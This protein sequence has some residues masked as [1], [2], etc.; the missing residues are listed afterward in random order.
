MKVTLDFDNQI[1]EIHSGNIEDFMKLIDDGILDVN[2]RFKQSISIF[3][4]PTYP[5]I[6]DAN[7]ITYYVTN[8]TCV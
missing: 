6:S 1:A 8:P 3:D 7:K 4:P 2:W 5:N